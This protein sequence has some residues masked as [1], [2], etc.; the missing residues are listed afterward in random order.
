[1]CNIHI[2]YQNYCTTWNFQGVQF[3]KNYT[4]KISTL[5]LY[6]H[7]LH[8]CENWSH[9]N[10]MLQS[11]YLQTLYP[12]KLYE[13]GIMTVCT[14]QAYSKNSKL[15]FNINSVTSTHIMLSLIS[16]NVSGSS[17]IQT[18]L[19]SNEMP[20]FSTDLHNL[21]PCGG[22]LSILNDNV[23]ILLEPL[24]NKYQYENKT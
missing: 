24:T 10:L 20:H 22:I 1:M 15:K 13:Y 21:K 9:I 14:I 19:P 17:K 16:I 5:I 4:R 3:C 7:I 6:L 12:V 11:G 23:W 18:L 2:M 8:I